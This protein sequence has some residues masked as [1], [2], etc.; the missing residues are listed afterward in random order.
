MTGTKSILVIGG[1]SDIGHAT[2]LRYAREGWRVTLAARDLEAAQ[3]NADD[4][5]TRSG[6]EATVQALD[7]L[8][9]GQLA[10]FV[11]GLSAL[12]DTVVCVVG[13]L[14]D[15]LRA[16][17]DPEL[18]TTIMR[19]NFE[20]P[21]LLLELFAQAFEARG[22]GTIVGVS[23]V[24]GDRGRASNYYYGAAKAGFSQFLS[25]LRNRLAL[26]GK[27]RVVTV[28]PGFVRTK[29]TAHMKLPAP[30]TVQP[31][32]VAEDIFR[33]D[34]MKPRDVIYVARRFW[35]VMTIICALPEPVFKRMRI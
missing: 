1:S 13:E 20:A 22:S 34:V 30:L 16:Q 19:T 8:Q 12:P 32:R 18:A 17:T 15:Q 27:V 6:V 10:G 26:A 4:I 21:S 2:A 3:R 14:G 23:S 25:G 33:A 31:D 5:R 35:L 11:A 28:K 7:V 24:A 9:T 29:M